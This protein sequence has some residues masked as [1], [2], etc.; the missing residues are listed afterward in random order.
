[1]GN[2][3]GAPSMTSSK[4]SNSSVTGRRYSAPSPTRAPPARRASEQS[5][6]QSQHF[7]QFGKGDFDFDFQ[8]RTRGRY[9][10]DRD[11]WE[12]RLVRDT[13]GSADDDGRAVREET[14]GGRSRCSGGCWNDVTPDWLTDRGEMIEADRVRASSF[15]SSRRSVPAAMTVDTDTGPYGS[16]YRHSYGTTRNNNHRFGDGRQGGS[17]ADDGRTRAWCLDGGDDT[18]P[19]TAAIKALDKDKNKTTA[20][21]GA[22]DADAEDTRRGSRRAA[23]VPHFTESRG[24]HR[25]LFYQQGEGPKQRWD[26]GLFKWEAP[27][28]PAPAARSVPA[29]SSGFG[30]WRK[31]PPINGGDGWPTR[32]PNDGGGGGGGGEWPIGISSNGSRSSSRSSG[33]STGKL[34]VRI[35]APAP[36]PAH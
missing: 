19:G 9:D 31:Q 1:M 18:L 17:N 35:S 4:Q 32:T 22:L 36:S 11:R 29:T 20:T 8:P 5:E 16:D 33:W 21:I 2:W 3:P 26:S 27:A 10:R 13:G 28:R 15:G 14:G 23:A 12:R 30:G 25:G 6:S 24:R 34:S 7:R